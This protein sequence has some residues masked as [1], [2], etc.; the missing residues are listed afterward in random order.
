[1]KWGEPLIYKLVMANLY[2]NK[3]E[4]LRLFLKSR[5]ECYEYNTNYTNIK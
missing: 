2:I 5:Y 1:M 3:K 4:S